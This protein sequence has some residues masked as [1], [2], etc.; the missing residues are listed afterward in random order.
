VHEDTQTGGFAGEIIAT[1]ASQAFMYL[2]APV[3]RLT[4]PD[5]LIPYN[6]PMME[7]VIPSV[8]TIRRKIETLL[9]Y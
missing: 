8:E 7:A 6:I 2:D 3:E 5:V 4:T 9:D 1:I